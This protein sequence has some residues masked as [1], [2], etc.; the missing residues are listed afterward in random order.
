MDSNQVLTVGVSHHN[1]VKCIG[2]FN[3]GPTRSLSLHAKSKDDKADLIAY[4]EF[5][6][7]L[8]L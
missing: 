7:A 2:S 3:S 4:C 1:S 6:R 8:Q 5:G